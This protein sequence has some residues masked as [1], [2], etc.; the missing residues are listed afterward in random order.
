MGKQKKEEQKTGRDTKWL[1]M[2]KPKGDFTYISIWF[3]IVFNKH[4]LLLQLE[5]NFLTF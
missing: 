4:A 3:K 2:V 1:I 5:Q